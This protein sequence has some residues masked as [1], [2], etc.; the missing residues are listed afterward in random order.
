[1]WGI[2]TI[3]YILLLPLSLT[4]KCFRR[5]PYNCTMVLH[6]PTFVHCLSVCLLSPHIPFSWGSVTGGDILQLLKSY[7]CYKWLYLWIYFCLSYELILLIKII[8]KVNLF[9]NFYQLNIL[10][11]LILYPLILII[12]PPIIWWIF[13]LC[14]IDSPYNFSLFVRTF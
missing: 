7:Y 14:T 6:S 9:Y 11:N 3:I 12:I 1:M 13:P 4:Q 8:I 5:L 2:I 10:R